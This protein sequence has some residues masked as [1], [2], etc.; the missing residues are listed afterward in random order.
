MWFYIN[1][2]DLEQIK[3][4]PL[5]QAGNLLLIDKVRE[6]EMVFCYEETIYYWFS[7]LWT[8]REKRCKYNFN[9]NPLQLIAFCLLNTKKMSKYILFSPTFKTVTV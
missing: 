9:Q 1:W 5:P 4:A 2:L 3:I 8:G 7:N 6:N